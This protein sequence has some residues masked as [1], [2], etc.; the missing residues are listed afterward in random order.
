MNNLLSQTVASLINT[1]RPRA[2]FR[3]GQLSWYSDGLLAGQ[4]GFDTRQGQGIYLYSTA[5]APALGPIQTVSW[6]KRLGRE[7][8]HSSPYSDEI[9][10]GGAISPFP[11]RHRGVVIKVHGQLYLSYCHVIE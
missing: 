6:V 3:K 7:A 5:S 9:K 1:T 8:D 4:P 2:C 11:I 10:N